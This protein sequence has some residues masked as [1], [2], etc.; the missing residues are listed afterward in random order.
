MLAEAIVMARRARTAGQPIRLFVP[1]SR[2]SISD[3]DAVAQMF[4]SLDANRAIVDALIFSVS[5]VEW[6][7][8]PLS[9]KSILSQIGHRG[10]T[11]SLTGATSLRFDYGELEGIG[12][13]SV[14]FDASRFLRSPEEFT[15]FHTGDIAPYAKRYHIDL[16]ATGIVDEQQLLSF[17]ED[18]IVLVQGRHIS[19]PGPVREDLLVERPVAAVASYRA[20][21]Q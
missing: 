10:V 1:I 20:E 11:F 19:G 16:V 17:F 14:R 18:G 13:T 8:M 5:Q 21:A 15:D 6:K 4:A 7:A 9:E 3:P 12:F 2:A